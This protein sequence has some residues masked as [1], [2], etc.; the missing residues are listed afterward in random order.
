VDAGYGGTTCAAVNGILTGGGAMITGAGG[1]AERWQG[2]LKVFA[3]P[4][5]TPEELLEAINNLARYLSRPAGLK[6]AAKMLEG[7]VALNGRQFAAGI[8]GMARYLTAVQVVGVVATAWSNYQTTGG[9]VAETAVM[10]TIDMGTVWAGAATGAYI[11]SLIPVPGVGT[12]VGL[13][14]GGLA[15]IA[16]TSIANNALGKAWDK[17]FG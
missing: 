4:A 17:V 11:G 13:L 8:P 2:I 1:L 16:Y 14:V 15:G 10:T 7:G 9:N 6:L 5:A 12:G 3:N